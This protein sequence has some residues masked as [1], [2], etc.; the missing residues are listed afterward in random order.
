MSEVRGNG[1][2]RG[3]KPITNNPLFKEIKFDFFNEGASEKQTI[4]ST[5]LNQIKETFIFIHF[6]ES[7]IC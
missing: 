5:S 2:E 1:W 6:S 4:R 7:L 3:V